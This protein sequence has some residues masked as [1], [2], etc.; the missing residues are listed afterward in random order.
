MATAFNSGV[1]RLKRKPATIVA[2]L[3]WLSV[4]GSYIAA[5]ILQ[6]QFGFAFIP[7]MFLSLPWSLLMYGVAEQ[8]PVHGIAA[9][10]YAALCLFLSGLNALMLYFLVTVCSAVVSRIVGQRRAR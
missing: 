3:Y 9:T 6:D 1:G 7:F 4:A 5:L 2:G 8:I 10:G